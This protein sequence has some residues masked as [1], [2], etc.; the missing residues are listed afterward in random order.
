VLEVGLLQPDVFEAGVSVLGMLEG[1]AVELGALELGVSEDGILELGVSHPDVFEAGG[2]EVGMLELSIPG[3]GGLQVGIP[4]GGVSQPDVLGIDAGIW[5]DSVWD[6]PLFG[7]ELFRKRAARKPS[8]NAPPRK[9]A[10]FRRA[11]CSISS[12]N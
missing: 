3:L 5:V 2:F 7:L 4:E 8:A 11:N 12:T 6:P 9:T 1:A 10:G